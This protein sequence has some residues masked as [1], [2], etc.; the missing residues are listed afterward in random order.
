MWIIFIEIVQGRVL[1]QGRVF[2]TPSAT[3]TKKLLNILAIDV[4]SVV[5]LPFASLSFLITLTWEFLML[6][7]DF[8]PVDKSFIL[9]LLIIGE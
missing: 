7:M 3:F 9:L 6:I 5:R 8:I 2:V 1:G 4:E